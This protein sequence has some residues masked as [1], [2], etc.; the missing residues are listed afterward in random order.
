MYSLN[1]YMT[2]AQKDRSVI[3][4]LFSA[5]HFYTLKMEAANSTEMTV[6]TYHTTLSLN[7]EDINVYK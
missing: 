1:G 5:C 4:T 6:H 7:S 2:N 3:S